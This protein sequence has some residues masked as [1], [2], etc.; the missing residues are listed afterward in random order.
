MENLKF[1]F[2]TIICEVQKKRKDVKLFIL[3]RSKNFV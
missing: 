2:L 3:I 1:K